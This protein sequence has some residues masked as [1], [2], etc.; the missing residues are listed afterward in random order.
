MTPLDFGYW[1]RGIVG[2]G[3]GP[4]EIGARVLAKA[5]EVLDKRPIKSVPPTMTAI[6]VPLF[7]IH[8]VNKGEYC[9]A[10]CGKYAAGK[11][12]TFAVTLPVGAPLVYIPLGSQKE[13][14]NGDH[15]SGVETD[16]PD[17]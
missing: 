7:C 2:V 12:R 5:A 17:A 4:D 10:C 11:M 6:R 8:N 9:Q 3:L 16:A 15:A 13:S 1:I 14:D